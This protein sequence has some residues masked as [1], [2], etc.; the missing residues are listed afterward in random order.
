M[1]YIYIFLSPF[2][3]G[4]TVDPHPNVE[5][6]CNNAKS[7][8]GDEEDGRIIILLNPPAVR[9]GPLLDSLGFA[10]KV[11]ELKASI[12][13]AIPD[14]C[15]VQDRLAYIYAID[16]TVCTVVCMLISWR[17]CKNTN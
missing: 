7:A 6:M 17:S 5:G 3:A 14:S 4:I 13:Q 8:G 16:S 11:S 12:K 15:L 1:R 10:T 9:I 2:Q